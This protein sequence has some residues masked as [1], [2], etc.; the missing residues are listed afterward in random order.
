[1][2]RGIHAIRGGYF[3]PWHE[4]WDGLFSLAWLV[5]IAWLAYRYIP[6]VQDLLR[7]FPDHLELMWRSVLKSLPAAGAAGPRLYWGG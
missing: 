7:D 1:M 6:A 2:R 5:F 4:A 3:H